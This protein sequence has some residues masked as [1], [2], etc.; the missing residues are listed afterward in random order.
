MWIFFIITVLTLILRWKRQWVHLDFIVRS[1][2][3]LYVGISNYP[4]DKTREAA[5]ISA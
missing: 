5:K 4:A 3:A 2:K 1:G